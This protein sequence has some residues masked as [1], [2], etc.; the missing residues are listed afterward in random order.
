MASY[1]SLSNSRLG[2]PSFS[3]ENLIAFLSLQVG[4]GVRR[5]LALEPHAC[6]VWPEITRILLFKTDFPRVLRFPVPLDE[7]SGD[8]IEEGLERA[9]NPPAKNLHFCWKWRT[10]G[11]RGVGRELFQRLQP[12][13]RTITKMQ[14]NRLLKILHWRFFTSRG[15]S[16]R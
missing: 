7:G 11:A 14:V 5:H 13:P 6:A 16:L 4:W 8:E 9:N 3:K 2:L 10:S 1:C 15:L 12:S